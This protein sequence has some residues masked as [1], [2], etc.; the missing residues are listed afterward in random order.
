MLSPFF[1]TLYSTVLNENSINL[2][3]FFFTCA[4]ANQYSATTTRSEICEFQLHC[5]EFNVPRSNF[6]IKQP[7]GK[8]HE[9]YRT[10]PDQLYPRAFALRPNRVLFVLAIFN[11]VIG[12]K[13][14]ALRLRTS[15]T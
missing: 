3:P 14:L 4:A 11:R 9:R 13:M 6:S 10:G 5:I 8:K 12:E 1:Q 7:R 15:A 2:L